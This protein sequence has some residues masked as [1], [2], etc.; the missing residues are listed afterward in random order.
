MTHSRLI[1]KSLL[2][3]SRATDVINFHVASHSH[4]LVARQKMS[5][6][7]GD[8]SMPKYLW[9]KHIMTRLSLSNIAPNEFVMNMSGEFLVDYDEWLF[10]RSITFRL[11][12]FRQSQTRI[13]FFSFWVSDRK[14]LKTDDECIFIVLNM[15]S[16]ARAFKMFSVREISRMQICTKS[17]AK[18]NKNRIIK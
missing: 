1:H 4:P 8:L 6:A 14:L 9:P 5:L 17:E 2:R 13:V 18:R 10:K 15:T 12:F 7:L 16:S 3:L 11:L